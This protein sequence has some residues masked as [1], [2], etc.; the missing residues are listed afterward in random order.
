MLNHPREERPR[1]W[2]GFESAELILYGAV[3]VLLVVVAGLALASEVDNIRG[4]LTGS[5]YSD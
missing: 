4:Y 2:C 1:G 3:G 5:R